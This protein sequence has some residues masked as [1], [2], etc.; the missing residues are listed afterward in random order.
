MS[1]HDSWEMRLA[2]Q[3]ARQVRG[4]PPDDLVLA[5]NPDRNL[6][7]H[8]E[9][10][11]F[12]RDLRRGGAERSAELSLARRLPKEWT[13]EPASALDEGQVRSLRADLAGWGPKR[14]FHHPP[15][16]LITKRATG[17]GDG[18]S[19]AQV[20]DDPRLMGPGDLLLTDDL[21]AETWNTYTLRA[22]YLDRLIATVPT[23]TLQAVIELA[24]KE[25]LPL[26]EHHPITAFRRLELEVGAFFA[27]RAVSELMALSRPGLV[28]ALAEAFPDEPILL[29]LLRTGNPRIVWLGND[30]PLLD[31][32]ALARFP[33]D[34][35]PLAA[36]TQ[37][38]VVPVNVLTM[39]PAG[40]AVSFAPGLAV[41]SVW[42]AHGE[43]LL[44][45]GQLF[46]TLLQEG[47]LSA[48]LE[49]PDGELRQAE[50]TMLD[51]QQGHFLAF[52]PQVEASLHPHCRLHL[53][54]LTR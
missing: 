48:R 26:A 40:A 4:C 53:L 8:L 11:P 28:E 25:L 1:K 31:T 23:A 49:L 5:E 45:G 51:V 42:R 9:V 12:C 33:D 3:I 14:L 17:F 37:Q 24:A 13:D 32:L 18:L 27:I 41:L 2:W 46:G 7:E 6:V 43:G 20:Y 30:L 54:V 38:R 15:L 36:S 44:A 39:G 10:C 16:V 50:E 47:E 35:V 21:F 29:D 22:D 19:V 34:E 52:F